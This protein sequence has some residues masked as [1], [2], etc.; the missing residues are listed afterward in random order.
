[1]TFVVIACVLVAVVAVIAVALVRRYRRRQE[2][3]IKFQT[4][5]G[6]LLV[7]TIKNEENRLV[8]VM[9]VQG[10]YES[11]TYL[12]DDLV[13][14]L[15]FDYHRAY[16]HV[17]DAGF[18]ITRTLML[19][20]GGYAYPKY[21]VSHYPEI[22]VDVVEIDP[23]VTSIAQRYFFLDRLVEEFETEETGQLECICADG[24]DYLEELASVN[25]S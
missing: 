15:V 19:G 17:F 18:P 13:Y 9:D 7:Y 4:M 14:E 23:M 20:G 6:P 16:N 24:R 8:R 12:A 5:A 22:H 10:A 1:M 11:A 2:I 25:G 21:I 3:F